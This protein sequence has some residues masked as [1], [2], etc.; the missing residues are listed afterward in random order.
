VA[1]LFWLVHMGAA[2]LPAW[3]ATVQVVK[4]VSPLLPQALRK[5]QEPRARVRCR[6]A[7]QAVVQ[8][9][10]SA[11]QVGAAAAETMQLVASGPWRW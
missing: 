1:Q 8:E 11:A 7:D 5:L 10:M 2:I 6:E 3:C 9:A 4:P